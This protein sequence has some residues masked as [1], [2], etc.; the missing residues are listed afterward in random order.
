MNYSK[1]TKHLL[2]N[3]SGT[4]LQILNLRSEWD[5]KKLLKLKDS[6][7]KLIAPTKDKNQPQFRV[8]I[9]VPDEQ[10][11]DKNFDKYYKKVNGEIQNFIFETLGLKTTFIKCII[12]E[13]GKEIITELYDGNTFI[14]RVKEKNRYEQL[15]NIEFELF[16]LNHSAKITFANKMGISTVNYGSVSLYKNNFRIYPFGEPGEDSLGLDKRK[17]QGHSRFLGTRDL[18]GKINIIGKNDQLKETSSRGDGLIKTKAYYELVDC[19]YEKVLKR[20][21]KYV[22]DVQEWGLSIEEDFNSTEKDVFMKAVTDNL[23][24]VTSDD[25]IIGV[26]YSEDIGNLIANVQNDS[27]IAIARNLKRIA[28]ESGDERLLAL[29]LTVEQKIKSFSQAIVESDLRSDVERLRLKSIE[30][31]LS[32]TT[33]ENLFLKSIKSQDFQEVVSLLHHIGIYAGT[34]DNYLSGLY[35]KITTNQEITTNEFADI[36]KIVSLEVKKI[37]NISTFATKANFKLKTEFLETNVGDYLE[38]YINNIIPTMTS[39][40]LKIY[41]TNN[42]PTPF[43]SLIRPIELNIVIDNLIDNAKKAG[44]SYIQISL[45][46]NSEYKFQITVTDNGHGIP[47]S[48]LQKVFNF[49]FTTTT[50]SGLGLYHVNQIVEKLKGN[51]KLKSEEGKGS[52]FTITL[53]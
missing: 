41:F 45:N 9:S 28:L 24:K 36:L 33:S 26:E 15:Q 50:G 4:E 11:E 16:F 37:M 39:K 44:A 47:S 20:L 8:F 46:R 38:E 12:S 30:K 35:K 43:I 49:G 42:N 18:I 1:T 48:N 6:L 13:N 53:N 25:D 10:E 52:T 7:A 19:F 29:A 22:V 51:I 2:S 3:I 40:N 5:R 14:Y 17:G 32:E 34:I 21:E 27:A 31:E 23:I